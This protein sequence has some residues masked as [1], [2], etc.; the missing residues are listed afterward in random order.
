MSHGYSRDSQVAE[1]H[2]HGISL[3]GFHLKKERASTKLPAVKENTPLFNLP[4]VSLI[5]KHHSREQHIIRGKG[6]TRHGEKREI[7]HRKRSKGCNER[8]NK[9]KRTKATSFKEKRKNYESKAERK[10]H[11]S[12][13][14]TRWWRLDVARQTIQ[15]QRLSARTCLCVCDCRLHHIN[16]IQENPHS[17]T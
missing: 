17:C 3:N 13:F 15:Y 5:Q 2:R 11:K 8:E 7:C 6:E 9:Q 16:I 14:L 12:F 10:R 4:A 1:L